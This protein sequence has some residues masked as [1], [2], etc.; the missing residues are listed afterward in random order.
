M[1]DL[2][3]RRA[4]R[5]N[6]GR[7]QEHNEDNDKCEPD[8]RNRFVFVEVFPQCDKCGEVRGGRERADV[9]DQDE[10]RALDF[11]GILG[12]LFMCQCAPYIVVV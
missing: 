7:E 1:L 6:H 3:R 2:P 5:S 9:E 8:A 4:N 10:V 11:E 12:D